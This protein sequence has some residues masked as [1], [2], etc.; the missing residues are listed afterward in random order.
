MPQIVAQLDAT[1]LPLFCRKFRELLN[2]TTM[3][4][5]KEGIYWEVIL[6]FI[7]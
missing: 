7:N 5:Q 4:E 1:P 6:H 2:F 3:M